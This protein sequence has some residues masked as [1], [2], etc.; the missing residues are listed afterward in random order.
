MT[1]T[2]R[3]KRKDFILN[4]IRRIVYIWMYIDARSTN[5]LHDGITFKRKEPYVMLGNHTFMF[6]VVHVPLRFRRSP[7]IVASQTLFNKR[8]L[9]F[10]LT[11]IAHAIPK[12]KGASDIRTA[13]ALITATRKGYPI[14]IFPEGDTTFFGETNYIEESTYKLIK[15]LKLDVITATVRGGYLSKPRWAK[16]KRKNRR[17]HIDYHI[18]ISKE[19]LKEMS[20]DEIEARIKNFLYNNDYEYQREV[21]IKHPGKDLANGFTDVTYICPN[22]NGIQTIETSGNKL[23][24]TKCDTEGQINEYGFIEGF[25]FDNLIDWDNYQR[26]HIDLLKQATFETKADLFYADYDTGNTTLVGDV[27]LTYNA[28]EFIF[29][30]ALDETV[31]L[32]DIKNPVLTLRRNLNFTYQDRNFFVRIDRMP[33]SFLRV[34]QEK[35]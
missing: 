2:W 20:V 12:S 15:K 26:E 3:D 21:M 30:G 11:H 31:P 14:L 13:K 25:K 32:K 6:D 27:N 33:M 5:T 17:I 19:E 29:T 9:G 24:C 1:R 18:A 16:G 22:C 28:G 34:A 4:L 8:G 10:V 35:Y 7:Y 23:H